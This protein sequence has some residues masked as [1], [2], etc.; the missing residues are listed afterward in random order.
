MANR[1]R[2]ISSTLL[3]VSPE[4][5]E[6]ARSAGARQAQITRH[7]TVPLAR[8]GLIGSWL[9]MF[10]IFEREYSTGVYLLT[11]GTETIGSMLVSLWATGA[12]DIVAALSFINILLVVI[13]M[14]VALRFGVKLHD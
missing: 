2:L 10:L 8:Y 9:L 12:I 14:G 13:G 6:A 3:Q 1:P 7:I 11:P 5:E 4:L